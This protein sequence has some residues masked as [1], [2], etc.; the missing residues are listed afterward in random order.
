MYSNFLILFTKYLDQFLYTLTNFYLYLSLQ[1]IKYY[2]NNLKN[3]HGKQTP[4]CIIKANE[5][6]T[7]LTNFAQI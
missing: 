5:F 6:R 3:G 4:M 2:F 1:L 7:N